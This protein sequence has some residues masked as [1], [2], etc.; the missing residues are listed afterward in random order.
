M[1]SYISAALLATA[2]TAQAQWYGDSYDAPEEKYEECPKLAHDEHLDTPEYQAMSAYCKQQLIWKKVIEDRT[3]ER[4]F[5]GAEF[6][7]TFDQDF[8]HTFDTVSD[9]MPIGRI[10]KTHPRGTTT[11]VEFIP[12]HDTPYTGIFEG[13]KHAVMRISEFAQTTPEVAKT[14]PGHA[15][16]FL[17]DGM[18]SANWFAMFAF[19]GQPSF[20]FFKNRWTNI[21]Q[22]PSNECA[23]DTIGKKQASVSDHIGALSVMEL[24][25]FDQY[26][27][28]VEYPHWPFMLEME[29][30]DVYGWT[31]AYQNDFHEQ[32]SAAL[33]PNTALFKIFAYDSPPEYGAEERLIGYL[34]SRSETTASLF[35]DQ[36][37]FFQ[38]RR[39]EDDIMHRPHYFDWLQFWDNGKFDESPL[40]NPAP[41][42]KCP[43]SFL[44]EEAGL[45]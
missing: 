23:R 19:D 14:S 37:L 30:Y 15:V 39:Y 3:P 38:H 32:L 36:K 33:K 17:R 31:D 13:C 9:T 1:R 41:R 24:A 18:S 42:Q 44:F 10:K 21:L 35:G 16:E 29:P 22:E 26:G 5:V 45:L 7:S 40:K 27:N 43:F 8:N 28:K 25:E 2:F 34:V 11:L 4:F 20:N 6:Q 12:T